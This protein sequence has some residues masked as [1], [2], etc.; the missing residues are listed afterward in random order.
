MCKSINIHITEVVFHFFNDFIAKSEAHFNVKVVRPYINN[1]REYLSNEMKDYC[2]EKG[3]SY[4]LT[5]V[6][7]SFWTHDQIHS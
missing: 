4:H 1:G 7:W 2:S 6:K 5:V 3:I